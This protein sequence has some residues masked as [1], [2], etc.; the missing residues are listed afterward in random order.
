MLPKAEDPCSNIQVHGIF[1]K[2]KF[3][4]FYFKKTK[5][6]EIEGGNGHFLSILKV[7]RLDGGALDICALCPEFI[8]QS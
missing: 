6:D 3:Y 1:D 4:F 5:I 2:T 7:G 8:T